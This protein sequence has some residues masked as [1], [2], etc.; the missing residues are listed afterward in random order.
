MYFIG[1]RIWYKLLLIAFWYCKILSTSRNN[2]LSVKRAQLTRF[3]ILVKRVIKVRET[4]WALVFCFNCRVVFVLLFIKPF[5]YNC[6]WYIKTTTSV[7]F[8]R[9]RYICPHRYLYVKYKFPTFSFDI[10]CKKIQSY[11]PILQIKITLTCELAH[12]P[13]SLLLWPCL[14]EENSL[15][16][17]ISLSWKSELCQIYFKKRLLGKYSE[18]AMTTA[19]KSF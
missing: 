7:Y 8:T 2:K 16:S 3:K 12:F 13:P 11:Y 4:F 18:Y 19:Q 17:H 1:P 10:Q 6:N 9:L 14:L 15:D 5:R